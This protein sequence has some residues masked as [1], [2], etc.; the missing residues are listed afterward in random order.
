MRLNPITYLAA[1]LL[2]PA[3]GAGFGA[4]DDDA[5]ADQAAGI[6]ALTPEHLAT[7]D[8]D[9]SPPA[10]GE[11]ANLIAS[12]ELEPEHVVEFY[13]PEPGVVWMTQSGADG[14]TPVELMRDDRTETA[15]DV[16]RRLAPGAE[17]PGAL[18]AA[19]E[20]AVELASSATVEPPPSEL[21]SVDSFGGGTQLSPFPELRP[22]GASQAGLGQVSQALTAQQFVNGSASGGSFCPNGGYAHAYTWCLTNWWNGAWYY[23]RATDDTWATVYADIGNIKMNVSSGRGGGQWTVNQG[24]WRQWYSGWSSCGFLGNWCDFH[25]RYDITEATNN[26]FHFGGAFLHW[27]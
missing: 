7:L 26:R 3:C 12:I 6:E 25:A 13:E 23:S 2:F 21:E 11:T 27:D 19:Q 9:D 4:E 8:A 18:L 22:T 5:G 1:L 10:H 20:R 16:Y 14:Q 17:V 24:Y 15:I